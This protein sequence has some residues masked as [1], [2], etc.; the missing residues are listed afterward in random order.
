MPPG[1]GGSCRAVSRD[2]FDEGGGG[3]GGGAEVNERERE[4]KC[5]YLDEAST[6][7]VLSEPWA[8]I[9]FVEPHGPEYTEDILCWSHSISNFSQPN[10]RKI[11]MERLSSGP[12]GNQRHP[13]C[14]TFSPLP[15]TMGRHFV[16]QYPPT[17]VHRQ[18][19]FPLLRRA[20]HRTGLTLVSVRDSQLAFTVERVRGEVSLRGRR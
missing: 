10:K 9:V 20:D 16:G 4:R 12:L 19:F 14:Y 3:L 15:A 1:R 11:W 7:R 8:S 2:R 6:K 13:K 17:H 18:A 5:S